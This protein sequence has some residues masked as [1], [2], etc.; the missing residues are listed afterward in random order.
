MSSI[1]T[2]LSLLLSFNAHADFGAPDCLAGKSAIAIDN[3]Q[4]ITWKRTT[5]NQFHAR[6][7]VRGVLRQEYPDRSGH[8]HLQIQI[9]GSATNDTL[10]VVYND[11]FGRLPAMKVGTVIEACGDYITSNQPTRRYPASPDGAIIHWVHKSRSKNHESGYLIIDGRTS[12][13]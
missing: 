5:K 11:S 2:A 8:H 1:V 3:D 12:G 4:V 10:E 7:H 6:G 9:D 13:L